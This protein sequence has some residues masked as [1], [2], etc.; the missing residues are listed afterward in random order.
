MQ[1]TLFNG[2]MAEPS[3]RK[4]FIAA[5]EKLAKV[6]PSLDKLRRKFGR[7]VVVPAAILD[8]GV[9]RGRDGTGLA[10]G[11][12]PD[13]GSHGGAETHGVDAVDDLPLDE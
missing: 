2:A 5:S 11:A 1:E 7:G 10:G 12:G 9:P 3:S 4:D 6:T 13:R 8:Q